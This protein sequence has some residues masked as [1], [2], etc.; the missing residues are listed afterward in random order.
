MAQF[1]LT[2][3]PFDASLGVEIVAASAERVVARLEIRADHLQPAGLVHGGI[4]ATLA[5]TTASIGASLAAQASGSGFAAVGLDNHTSFLYAVGLGAK[6]V[7]TA[8]PR[9]LGRHVQAWTVTIHDETSARDV[10]ITTM[11]LYVIDQPTSTP[12]PS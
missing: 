10:A 9:H 8:V 3:S 4:H 7:A 1:D 11:R 12:E 6:L 2:S 5:E